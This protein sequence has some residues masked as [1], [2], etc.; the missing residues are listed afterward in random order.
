MKYGIIDYDDAINDLH[1][2][3]TLSFAGRIQKPIMNIFE[4]EGLS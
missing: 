3:T 1:N 4:K 2:W